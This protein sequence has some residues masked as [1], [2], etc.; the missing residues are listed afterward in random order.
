MY[1][2]SPLSVDDLSGIL[3]TLNR[4]LT[5]HGILSALRRCHSI[6]STA[7]DS[8]INPYHAS[9]RDFLTDG[10]RSTTL[11]LP[12]ATC[13]GRLML[14]CLS[15]VTRA[16]SEGTD[17]P[18]YPVVSW[19]YHA[20]SFLITRSGDS[21]DLE[22]MKDEVQQLVKKIDLAWVKSWLI[23]ALYWETVSSL[24]FKLPSAKVQS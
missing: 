12:P 15:A 16:F 4:H 8:T 11:F 3:F 22:E 24:R 7:D 21:E 6:L 14:G 17:G 5:R 9:L 19:Y 20:C 1:L 23:Q 10:S 18:R 13:H 2:K